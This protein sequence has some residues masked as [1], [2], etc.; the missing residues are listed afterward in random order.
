MWTQGLWFEAVVPSSPTL[1]CYYSVDVLAPC[2]SSLRNKIYARKVLT[3]CKRAR[4]PHIF[5]RP[6]L[7]FQRYKIGDAEYYPRATSWIFTK[8]GFEAKLEKH[9]L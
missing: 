4:W 6:H 7:A 3:L 9:R 5:A 2:Q 8:L 1:G